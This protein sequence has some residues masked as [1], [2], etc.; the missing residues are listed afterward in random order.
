MEIAIVFDGAS[1]GN[2]GACGVGVIAKDGST[3]ETLEKL[4]LEVGI[5][6]NSF[7]EYSAFMEAVR[8]E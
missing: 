1:V 3:G 5:G 4:S 2:G 6:T 8:M 7:A